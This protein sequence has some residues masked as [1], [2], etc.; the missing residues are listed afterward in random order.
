MPQ[1]SGKGQKNWSD[2]TDTALA[3]GHFQKHILKIGLCGG[4]II[5]RDPGC[6]HDG[7]NLRRVHLVRIETDDQPVGAAAS[8]AG[9]MRAKLDKFVGQRVEDRAAHTK[10]K[11]LAAGPTN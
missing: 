8:A 2:E 4:H 10:V 1:I 9:K 11:F 3:A 5:N 6:I 7:N